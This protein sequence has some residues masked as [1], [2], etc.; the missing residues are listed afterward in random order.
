MHIRRGNSHWHISLVQGASEHDIQV[1]TLCGRN[2]RSCSVVL[3]TILRSE[4]LGSGDM[5]FPSIIQDFYSAEFLAYQ[6]MLG[7]IV[8][9]IG[10]GGCRSIACADVIVQM[11]IA[12][13]VEQSIISTPCSSVLR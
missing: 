3:P 6:V 2:N 4:Q 1:C 5:G 10:Y 9:E 13:A 7:V 12:I 8:H 11:S